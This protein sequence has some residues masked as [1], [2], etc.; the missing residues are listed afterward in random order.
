MRQNMCRGGARRSPPGF[1]LLARFKIFCERPAAIAAL[2]CLLLLAVLPVTA[3]AQGGGAAAQPPAVSAPKPPAPP[4]VPV[5]PQPKG[6]DV[7]AAPLPPPDFVSSPGQ[8]L[9]QSVA[10]A[11]PE[12]VARFTQ[13][14]QNLWRKV[15]RA[16]PDFVADL[17]V[18]QTQQ[19]LQAWLKPLTGGTILFADQRERREQA[20][21]DSPSVADTLQNTQTSPYVKGE[22]SRNPAAGFSPGRARSTPLLKALYGASPQ[23]VRAACETVNFLGQQIIFNARHGAAAALRRVARRLEVHLAEHPEDRVWILPLA[24]TFAH[25]QVAGSEALSAHA[26]AVAIDLSTEK[27]PYWRWRP[28]PDIVQ[29]ARDHFPQ[30]VV[31]AFEAERFIWGG[32]WHAFDF[33]HFEYRPEIIE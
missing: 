11:S 25:R 9:P 32:K 16:Y 8:L 4:A 15:Q 23:E 1:A 33:M 26:F 17:E 12:D 3:P 18:K 14:A 13:N 29:N 20:L 7:S 28:A 5:V 27:S 24:G 31:D 2:L 6:H 22:G 10:Y 21:W 30:A 19:G